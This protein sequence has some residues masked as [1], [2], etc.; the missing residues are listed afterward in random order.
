M[1]KPDV[2]SC[3]LVMY[4]IFINIQKINEIQ[5]CICMYFQIYPDDTH[6]MSGSRTHFYL[7]MEDFLTSCFDEVAEADESSGRFAVKTAAVAGI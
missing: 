1:V 7:S 6:S 3:N 2:V 5:P 4:Y